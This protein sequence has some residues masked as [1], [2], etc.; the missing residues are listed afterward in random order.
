VAGC[1]ECGD[2]PS[3]SC[4]T[5]LV[6]CSLQLKVLACMLVMPVEFQTSDHERWYLMLSLRS[7]V[8]AVAAS[9]A[10]LTALQTEFQRV[11]ASSS[12]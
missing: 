5:E 10:N 11:Y 3:G 6:I 12:E 4:A 2:E 8:M 9:H 1:C 7:S